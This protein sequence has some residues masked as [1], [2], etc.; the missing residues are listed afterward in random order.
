MSVRVVALAV[1]LLLWSPSTSSVGAA[2]PDEPSDVSLLQL[3]A[4]PRD[5]DGEL[6]RVIGFC[7]LEFEG[8]ALYLHR[9]DYEHGI[10]KNAIWLDVERPA[11]GLSN[12]YVLVE[13]VFDAGHNGHMSMFSGSLGKI[14]RM[15]RWRRSP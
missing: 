7:R 5:Y 9:E 4:N 6:V 1:L 8:N 11:S 15:E 14:R 10:S 2:A 3:I 12:Q 13:G